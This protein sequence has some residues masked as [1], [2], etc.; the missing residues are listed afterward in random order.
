VEA[1]S[2]RS[3]PGQIQGAG[4]GRTRATT[5]WLFA[6]ESQTISSPVPPVATKQEPS[7]SI[8][9]FIGVNVAVQAVTAFWAAAKTSRADA[10]PATCSVR[11][12][13]T[14]L[15]GQVALSDISR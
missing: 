13:R 4:L 8:S 14:P 6:K 7:C 5:E 9:I 2:I 1:P 3:A 11:L 15:D 12:R 10:V